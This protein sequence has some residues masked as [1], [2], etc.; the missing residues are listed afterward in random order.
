MYKLLYKEPDGDITC[1]S[2]D[3]EKVFPTLHAYEETELTPEQ[4]ED[5]KRKSQKLETMVTDLESKLQQVEAELFNMAAHLKAVYQCDAC[6]H[7][8]CECTDEPCST[9]MK[10]PSHP[11]WEWLNATDT[12]VGHKKED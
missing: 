4:I 9:C 2:A 3:F 6:K 10:D 8:T 1:R 7:T 11:N 5:M 12:N